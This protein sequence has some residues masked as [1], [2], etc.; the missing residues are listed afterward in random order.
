MQQQ[1]PRVRRFGPFI[2]WATALHATALA[3]ALLRPAFAESPPEAPTT[4]ASVGALDIEVEPP[5]PLLPLTPPGGGAPATDSK[6]TDRRPPLRVAPPKSTVPVP[7]IAHAAPRQPDAPA[8]AE[9]VEDA[10]KSPHGPNEEEAEADMAG[11]RAAADRRERDV[12]MA[13]AA[14]AAAGAGRGAGGGPGG[15]GSG[16]GRERERAGAPAIH[17]AIAFGNGSGG[18]LTGRVCFLPVGTS[19]I[20]DVH[21]CE[22]VATFFTDTLDIPERHFS[23][24]FPG[25]TNRSE[26]FLIDYT[27][28]FT[29]GEY[30][31][32]R[33]RLL[34][35]DGS[36]LY[37]DD[38]LVVDNDG[39]HAPESRYGSIHLVPG[40]HHIKV[41]YSQTNDRM[42]LQLFVRVPESSSETLFRPQL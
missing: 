38:T 29:V 24:G 12:A 31:S 6:D 27:G 22:Y 35:D 20:A 13:A 7:Q 33:F 42:A 40:E 18:A 8:A 3:A 26:W 4:Q 15:P 9:P 10:P 30:G 34:S 37:V 16:W 25:V 39:K 1:K 19:R 41:R 36:V 32:F 28:T 5:V 17:G 11:V 21:D 2:L 23:D 14:A